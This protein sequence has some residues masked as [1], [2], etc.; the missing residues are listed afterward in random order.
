VWELDE[1][2]VEAV[3]R[4]NVVGVFYGCKVAMKGMLAQG[5]GH[6]Y[7]ME[8]LGS[9]GPAVTGSSLYGS[10]KAALTYMTRVFVKEA[11]ETP[12]RVGFLSPG[13]VITDLFVGTDGANLDDELKKIA[14]ILADR[15]ETVTPFLVEKMLSDDKN[16]TRIDYLPMTKMIGRFLTAPFR[17]RDLFDEQSKP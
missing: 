2:T 14:N 5:S 7:N 12:V 9:K 1:E 15:V 4:T 8:G 16:G 11:E 3:V 6:I 13:M 17:K 10:T